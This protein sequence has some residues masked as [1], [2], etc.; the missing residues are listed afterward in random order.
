MTRHFRLMAGHVTD[1]R[2]VPGLQFGNDKLWCL[3]SQ[4]WACPP[5]LGRR[6]KNKPGLV[7]DLSGKCELKFPSAVALSP[8]APEQVLLDVGPKMSLRRWDLRRCE[9]CQQIKCLFKLPRTG[10]LQFVCSSVSTFQTKLLTSGDIQEVLARFPDTVNHAIFR[11]ARVQ[12][13]T[14]HI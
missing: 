12:S 14:V 4:L 6:T 9:E 11:Y 3:V 5:N 10:K 13:S 1:L 2:A 8:R 7:G